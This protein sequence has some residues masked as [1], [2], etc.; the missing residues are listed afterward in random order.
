M[1]LTGVVS[2]RVLTDKG[3]HLEWNRSS[4][5]RSI[6][7]S[8][9]HQGCIQGGTKM[10]GN[11]NER[12]TYRVRT[13]SESAGVVSERVLTL[14]EIVLPPLCVTESHAVARP[15]IDVLKLIVLT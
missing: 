7:Q 11:E 10:R 5:E 2:E 9:E 15:G 4:Y 13:G 8:Q 1:E 6:V 12:G 14:V 3:I